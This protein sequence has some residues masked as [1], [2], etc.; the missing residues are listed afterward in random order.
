MHHNSGLFCRICDSQLH[1]TDDWALSVLN[2][3]DFISGVLYCI[4]HI[5]GWI[6]LW[7]FLFLLLE[8]SILILEFARCLDILKISQNRDKT[9][10]WSQKRSGNELRTGWPGRLPKGL[11]S[12]PRLFHFKELSFL[13]LT[14]S[15]LE[16]RLY[17][18]AEN[19][20]LKDANFIFYF[21]EKFFRRSK[22]EINS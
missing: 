6:W 15:W 20:N 2:Q 13:F 12:S 18:P 4:N 11:N 9:L 3:A 21:D 10:P 19:T 7:C 22:S 14:S 1:A 16:N 8:Y 17:R 5:Y